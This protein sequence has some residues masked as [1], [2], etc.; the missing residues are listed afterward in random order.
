MKGF[1]EL[2]TEVGKLRMRVERLQDA[3]D[4]NGK[5]LEALISAVPGAKDQLIA[6]LDKRKAVEDD[7]TYARDLQR[8]LDMVEKGKA[9]RCSGGPGTVVFARKVEDNSPLAVEFESLTE[10][11]QALLT[12]KIE[13]DEVPIEGGTL[14]IT[15]VFDLRVGK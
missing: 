10:D 2:L 13:G 6:E 4:H 14:R 11:K 9:R 3:T 12:G 5:V 15:G 7:E 8:C 1:K